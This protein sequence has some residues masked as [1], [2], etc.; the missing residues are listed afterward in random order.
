MHYPVFVHRHQ[1][2]R[3]E[4][5]SLSVPTCAGRGENRDEALQDSKRLLEER[6]QKG[7]DSASHRSLLVERYLKDD[8]YAALQWE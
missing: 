3:Y 2:G 4:A 1:S 7:V 5:V 8:D 6:M